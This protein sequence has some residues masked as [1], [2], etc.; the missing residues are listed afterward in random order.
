M[1]VPQRRHTYVPPRPVTGIVLLLTYFRVQSSGKYRR[2]QYQPLT[3]GLGWQLGL[4]SLVHKALATGERDTLVLSTAA[5]LNTV[6]VLGK[7]RMLPLMDM[8]F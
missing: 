7:F 5:T 4:F 3:R 1:F 8:A 2:V 6:I